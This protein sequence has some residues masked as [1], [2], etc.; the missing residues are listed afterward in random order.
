MERLERAP[1]E[2]SP[3]IRCT[4]TC[5]FHETVPEPAPADPSTRLRV[6]LS[7]SK[8]DNAKGTKR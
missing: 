3:F 2:G 1:V 6:A 8:G 7:E 5:R 4:I